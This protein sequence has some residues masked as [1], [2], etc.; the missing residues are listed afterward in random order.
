[1]LTLPLP[2]TMLTPACHAVYDYTATNP[3]SGAVVT[4]LV[5]VNWAPDSSSTRTKMMYA[6]TK[7]FFK[8][9]CDID[10]P[11]DSRFKQWRCMNLGGDLVYARIWVV[12]G[13][14]C[15]FTHMCVC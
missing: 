15:M 3:E 4:K 14:L 11:I 7:D 10:A 8:V 2:A 12:L 13:G 9:S 6:S 5:F 1:M